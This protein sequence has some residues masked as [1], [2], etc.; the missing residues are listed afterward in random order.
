MKQVT[1]SSIP[2]FICV[3]SPLIALLQFVILHHISTIC[4][5][6]IAVFAALIVTCDFVLSML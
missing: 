6:G 4:K 3:Q 2:N 1:S 5:M